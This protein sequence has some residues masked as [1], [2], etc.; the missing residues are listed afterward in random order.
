M[1]GATPAGAA[2][3]EATSRRSA[4][5]SASNE[6]TASTGPRRSAGRRRVAAAAR[7]GGGVA[8]GVQALGR[9]VARMLVVALRLAVRLVRAD[10]AQSLKNWESKKNYK[11]LSGAVSS[12]KSDRPCT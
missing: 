3:R 9:A 8:Q 12:L 5:R 1:W 7:A 4:S 2:V 10:S 11:I 6:A